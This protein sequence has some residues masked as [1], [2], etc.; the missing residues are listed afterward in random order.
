MVGKHEHRMVKWRI[1]APP[2]PPRLIPPR[3]PDRPEHVAAHDRGSDVRQTLLDHRGAGVHI[4]A[5]LAVHLPKRLE[6]EEPLVQIHPAA[7]ERALLVLAWTGDV[8]VQRHRDAE[9]QLAHR[10]LIVI[11]ALSPAKGI[12]GRVS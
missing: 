12:M 10:L 1:L 6:R 7:T 3:T 4:A 2:T 11:P 9:S 8:A 5:L